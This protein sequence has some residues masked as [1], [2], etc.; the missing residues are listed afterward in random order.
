MGFGNENQSARKTYVNIVGGKLSVRAKEGDE[1]AV[2]RKNKNEVTVWEKHYPNLTGTFVNVECVLNEALKANEYVLT[3]DD[4]GTLYRLSIP[5]DSN[6]GDSFIVKLPNLKL[7]QIYTFTPYDFEDKE[8]KKKDGSP[9]RNTG[10]SIKLGEEK[11][12]PAFTK[13]NPNGRP[14]GQEG[15]DKDDYKVYQIQLRKFY[16]GVVSKFLEANVAPPAAS[17]QQSSSNSQVSNNQ[18]DS[19]LPFMI[20]ILVSLTAFIPF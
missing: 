7:N 1:G 11:I 17:Q 2:S 5:C 16:R 14:Q 8:R 15:M 4:I 6:Y 9:A 19:D 13:D 10:V 18:D 20:L 3:I 12:L